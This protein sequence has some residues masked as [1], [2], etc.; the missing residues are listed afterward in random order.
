MGILGNETANF[1]AD[2]AV[3]QGDWVDYLPSHTDLCSIMREKYLSIESIEKRLLAMSRDCGMQYFNLYPVFAKRPWFARL[4]LSR[5]EI[6]T[7]CR[8]RSNHYNLNFG[9]HRCDIVSRRNCPCS[10]PQQDIEHI[11]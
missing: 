11:L 3:R 7:A 1:L 6:V 2:K 8:I 10:A 9:L 4:R 5:S